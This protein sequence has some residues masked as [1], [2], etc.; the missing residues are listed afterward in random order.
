VGILIS[1]EILM[2]EGQT[3]V[4]I[5]SANSI[6]RTGIL[7]LLS[8]RSDFK[9]LLI[10]QV[11]GIKELIKKY[12]KFKPRVII[13]DYDDKNI[14]KK[15]FL[16]TFFEQQHD[17]QLLLVSLQHSG[18]IMFY[19]RQVLSADQA[20]QWLQIPWDESKTFL[21]LENE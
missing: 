12:S 10:H 5:A 18:N 3:H 17:A 21:N 6:F 15:V 2:E 14:N 11:S 20:H 1:L 13:I 19:K 4:L 9:N 7:K 16:D 8:K